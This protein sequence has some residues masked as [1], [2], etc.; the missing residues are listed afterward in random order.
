[1]DHNWLV[2]DQAVRSGAR[3]GPGQDR[4]RTKKLKSLGLD[5]PKTVKFWENKD[6]VGQVGRRTWRSVDPWWWG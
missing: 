4:A 2:Q 1:M 6:N 5:L 3:T